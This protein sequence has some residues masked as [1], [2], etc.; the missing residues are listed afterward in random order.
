[1]LCPRNARLLKG[2]GLHNRTSKREQKGYFIS[3]ANPFKPCAREVTRKAIEKGGKTAKYPYKQKAHYNTKWAKDGFKVYPS[4]KIELS[5][6]NHD[7]KREKP[8]NKK[9]AQISQLQSKCT[10]KSKRWKT[11]YIERP[12]NL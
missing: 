12:K 11:N 7:G 8:R 2:S 3:I 5:M 10:K 6:G 4:G 1:M 9:L